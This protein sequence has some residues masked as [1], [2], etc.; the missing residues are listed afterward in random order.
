MYARI[1]RHDDPTQSM[2]EQE[3]SAGK[4]DDN[5]DWICPTWSDAAETLAARIDAPLDSSSLTSA[6]TNS[7]NSTPHSSSKK[8]ARMVRRLYFH[9]CAWVLGS[10]T[11][12]VLGSI[13]ILYIKTTQQA[14]NR[15]SVALKISIPA[16]FTS[17]TRAD[18]ITLLLERALGST[19]LE[20]PI[21]AQAL[22]WIITNDPAQLNPLNS[23][24]IVQRFLAA[25]FYYSTSAE[26]T[27]TAAAGAGSDSLPPWNACGPPADPW[28]DSSLCT[29]Q[30][31]QYDEPTTS[32]K[33][34]TNASECQWAGLF[35]DYNGQVRQV[36]WSKL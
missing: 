8:R 28:K 15:N 11:V 3:T 34:L 2:T 9:G 29:Y 20:R 16:N 13:F 25:Y 23:S 4:P 35:C 6:V 33:W 19:T 36:E 27:A 12:A 1:M 14:R 5:D 31:E 10:L 22:Q 30:I 21:Y 26:S 17:L 32:Y 18:Q 7:T 24:N